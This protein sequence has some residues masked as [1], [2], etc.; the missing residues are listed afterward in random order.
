VQC[1]AGAGEASFAGKGRTNVLPHCFVYGGRS[2]RANSPAYQTST[3]RDRSAAL[4][5]AYFKTGGDSPAL[6]YLDF[7][8]HQTTPN[9]NTYGRVYLAANSDLKPDACTQPCCKQAPIYTGFFG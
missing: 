3:D 7:D 6:R 2:G 1:R 8:A 9:G 4:G 5:R